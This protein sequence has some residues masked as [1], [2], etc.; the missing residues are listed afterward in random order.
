MY[1]QKTLDKQ[2][3]KAYAITT[4]NK[5]GGV[6]MTD[7]MDLSTGTVYSYNAKPKEALIMCFEQISKGNYNTWNYNFEQQ[8]TESKLCYSIGDLA[9]FKNGRDIK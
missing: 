5:G 2:N 3:A 9:T 1:T 4:K 7:V 8:I 6:R